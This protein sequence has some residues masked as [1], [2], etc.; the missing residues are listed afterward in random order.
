VSGGDVLTLTPPLTISE[1][2]ADLGLSIL[3][4]ALTAAY[5]PTPE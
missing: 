3:D 5:R 4:A 2:D 1:D